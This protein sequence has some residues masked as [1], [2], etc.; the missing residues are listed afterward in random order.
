MSKTEMGKQEP[1][2]STETGSGINA[3]TN[4]LLD[5]VSNEFE[6]LR[7]QFLEK[8]EAMTH[9]LDSL[10][11]SMRASFNSSPSASPSA[12]SP[13]PNPSTTTKDDK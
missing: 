10:E 11:D 3:M 8:L 7:K 5:D 2:E 12:T 6:N 1:L 13:A 9:R 4:K